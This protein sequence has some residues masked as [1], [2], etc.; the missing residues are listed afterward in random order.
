MLTM[1]SHHLIFLLLGTTAALSPS[2]PVSN[3]TT[4]IINSSLSATP[5]PRCAIEPR[6]H[7]GN[8]RALDCLNVYTYILATTANRIQPMRY[9]GS[10]LARRST[11]Y[12]RQ[13]GTCEF[14]VSL[15]DRDSAK[16]PYL[17]PPPEIATLDEMLGRGLYV[18]SQ[19]L[20]DSRPEST[21]FGGIVRLKTGSNLWIA[22]GSVALRD[23]GGG[24]GTMS[25]DEGMSDQWLDAISEG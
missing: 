15:W 18:V 20:M 3:F 1:T 10:P 6:A 24:N 19:C 4:P 16:P 2:K 8:V 5:Q 14:V 12:S 11:V 22:M 21:H 25:L 7:G 9:A 23:G 13:S 17:P